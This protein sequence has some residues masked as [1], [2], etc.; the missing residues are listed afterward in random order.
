MKKYFKNWTLLRWIYLA[1]AIFVIVQGILTEEWLWVLLGSFF[2]LF[3][4]FNI[5]SC[6]LQNCSISTFN[7]KETE[8][9]TKKG[10]R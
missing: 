1:I 6:P 4:I 3:P 2:G 7:I 5:G 9:F 8:S 10:N